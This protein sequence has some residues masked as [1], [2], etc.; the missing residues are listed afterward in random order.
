MPLI[1]GQR[2][3]PGHDAADVRRIRGR[4]TPT[5]NSNKYLKQIHE[6]CKSGM[7]VKLVD[8]QKKWKKN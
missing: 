7:I 1:G 3:C 8:P 4:G 6:F 5:R 2:P